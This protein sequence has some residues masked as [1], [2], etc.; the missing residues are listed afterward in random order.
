LGP[1]E[2]GIDRREFVTRLSRVAA[3]AAAIELVSLMPLL[4]GCAEEEDGPLSEGARNAVRVCMGV[5]STD[6]VIVLTDEETAPVGDALLRET[7][8][9][10]ARHKS[11]LLEN[12]GRRQLTQLPADLADDVRSFGPSVTFFAATARQ[13]EFPMRRAFIDLATRELGAR[14]AHMPGI[15]PAIVR[16]GLS[17]DY[18][19]VGEITRDVYERLRTCTG[20]HVTSSKGTDL[21]A[22][23]SD[24]L[25][26]V[27]CDGSYHQ[28]G[29]WGNLP[30]GEVF[31][32]PESVDGVLVADVVGDYFSGKYGILPD[33]VTVEIADGLA[34]KITCANKQLEAELTSYLTSNENGGRV[35]EFAI[36]TNIGIK[37]LCGNLLQDEKI[38]G[39]HLA[40]GHPNG[41]L[42]GATWSSA[43]HVDMIPSDCTIYV[44]GE[45]LMEAGR[46][47]GLT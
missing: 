38:P 22:R 17:V 42:T 1:W 47:V 19:V 4:A 8:A 20:V 35:G 6:R 7:A 26:W 12:Y 3:A 31:T 30:E 2:D 21:V 14:H 41:D 43:T 40:F 45:L 5:D 28:S 25:R 9:V 34:G 29:E 23:F 27:P 39:V 44:D 16:E 36:G 13:G 15:T 37:A 10:D 11:V 33:P 46:F 24:A 18:D 32:C